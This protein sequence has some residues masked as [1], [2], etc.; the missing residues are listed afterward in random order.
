MI[1]Y[2]R[3]TNPKLIGNQ[4]PAN[5]AFDEIA[6]DLLAEM[7]A[8]GPSASLRHRPWIAPRSAAV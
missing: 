5:A 2:C 8:R 1:G 6:V 7:G 3:L 4:Q